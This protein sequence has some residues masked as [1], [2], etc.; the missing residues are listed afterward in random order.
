MGNSAVRY[1]E[2]EDR[3]MYLR[4]ILFKLN[5]SIDRGITPFGEQSDNQ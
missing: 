3:N 1:S 4:M 2:E 5:V